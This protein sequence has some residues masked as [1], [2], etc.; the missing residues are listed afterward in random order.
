MS[1]YVDLILEAVTL[2][3]MTI[4]LDTRTFLFPPMSISPNLVQTLSVLIFSRLQYDSYN[5]TFHG[6]GVEL[7]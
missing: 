2:P 6:E 5:N 3:Q 4:I 7:V 1:T